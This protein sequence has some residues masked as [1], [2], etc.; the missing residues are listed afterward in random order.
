M[1]L[2]TFI[3]SL[4][5]SLT[6]RNKIE[7]NLKELDIHGYKFF[8]GKIVDEIPFYI[9]LTKGELGCLLSHLTLFHEIVEKKLPFA[10]ILEDDVV[11]SDKLKKAM[12]DTNVFLSLNS[13]I[14]LVIL[15]YSLDA[16]NFD[17][18]IKLSFWQRRRWGENK[19]GKPVQRFYG[20]YAYFIT[21]EGASKIIELSKN[22]LIPSDIFINSL[23]T[24]GIQVYCIADPIVFPNEEN[25][26]STIGTRSDSFFV[27]DN[28]I[29]F[30]IRNKIAHIIIRKIQFLLFFIRKISWTNSKY[31]NLK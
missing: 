19:I 4:K 23:I 28:F 30:N 17:A 21:F 7:I 29:D 2:N 1:I 31:F 8:D 3:I 12:I 5:S 18:Q 24:K 9:S 20:S 6:R 26:T 25:N 11:V 14:D 15:G 16:V 10:F 27:N 22:V 13:D